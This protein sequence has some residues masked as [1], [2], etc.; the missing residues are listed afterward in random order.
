MKVLFPVGVCL[1]LLSACGESTSDT[2]TATDTS[3]ETDEKI[4]TGNYISDCYLSVSVNTYVV[5]NLSYST[6]SYTNTINYYSEADNSCAGSIESS[7][8]TYGTISYGDDVVS[9]DGSAAHRASFDN[10]TDGVAPELERVMEAVYR[11]TEMELYF[12][13]YTQGQLSTVYYSPAYHKQ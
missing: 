9:S 7:L 11:K 10:K 3:T 8:Y 2:S 4:F 6:D 12:G 1:L 5:E 13:P